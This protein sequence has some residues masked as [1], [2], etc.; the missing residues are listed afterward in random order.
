MNSSR[1]FGQ[2]RRPADSRVSATPPSPQEPVGQSPTDSVV[3]FQDGD[4]IRRP[5]R[6]ERRLRRNIWQ[7]PCSRAAARLRALAA[8]GDR[9]DGRRERR[10][11]LPGLHGASSHVL[12]EARLGRRTSMNE[13]LRKDMC[14]RPWGIVNQSNAPQSHFAGAELL[15]KGEASQVALATS[16]AVLAPSR[17]PCAGD[18]QDQAK[19]SS[20][21]DAEGR[22]RSCGAGRDRV[23]R[24]FPTRMRPPSTADHAVLPGRV[25]FQRADRREWL[26]S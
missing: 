11:R 7:R 12:A 8:T 15:R 19:T 23:R 13:I 10:K 16:N 14:T 21:L 26:S 18:A 17:S 6:S 20:E 2:G 25:A 4:G 1:I 24:T 22:T 9:K 5:Y 3:T